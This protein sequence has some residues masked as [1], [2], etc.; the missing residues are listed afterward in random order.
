MAKS[1]APLPLLGEAAVELVAARFRALGDPARLRILNALTAREL[2]VQELV[3][4]TGLEQPNVSKHLGL[5][6]REGIVARRSDGNR[7]FYRIVDPS[8]LELCEVVCGGLAER[9]AG[10]LEA[11]PRK[12]RSGSRLPGR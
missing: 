10:A 8:V 5:L 12:T 3:Q 11:L 1:R 2:S 6:R 7:A 4:A 9:L